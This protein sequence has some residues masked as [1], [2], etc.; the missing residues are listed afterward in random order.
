MTLARGFAADEGNCLRRAQTNM[1]R[2]GSRAD[3]KT[4][5]VMMKKADIGAPVIDRAAAAS[6]AEAFFAAN[7]TV[8][9]LDCLFVDMTGAIRGKRLP[10]EEAIK[11]LS[12]GVQIPQSLYLLD[13][14]GEMTDAL[15]RGFGDGDPDGTAFAVMS[16]LSPV[17]FADPPRAQVLMTLYE[18]SG[19]PCAIE[20]RNVL[21]SVVARFAE[22]DLT[23]TVAVELEFFLIDQK[24]TPGGMIQP[25]LCPRTGE[26]ERSIAVYGIDDL[27]RYSGFIKAVREACRMEH[28]PATAAS[29]EYAPGQFEINLKHTPDPLVAGDQAVFLKQCIKLAAE[30]EGMRATFMAKPYE[31]KAGSGMHVHMSL[32]DRGGIN[33]FNDGSA[34]GSP[35]LHHAAAGLAAIMHEGMAFFSQNSN[36][37]RRFVPN[38]FVPMNRRWGVNNRSTGIRVPAGLPEAKRLEHRV[39]AADAN[40]YLV[41]A[42]VLAGAHYGMTQKLD[43]GEPFVG[44]AAEFIDPTVPFTLEGALSALESSTILRGYLG[45]YIDSYVASKR[46]ERERFR[47]VITPHEYDWYL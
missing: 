15:G 6:E 14:R 8:T 36:A 25:P 27:D 35:L 44:N 10:R 42:V 32:V 16:T 28:V 12:N 19:E 17:A 37:Y 2:D 40:P 9:A 5:E 38:L 30:R 29:S 34:E 26:R 21:K 41:L 1:V 3:R 18:P 13:A 23:P 7:P 11:S 39:A 43:P 45:G 20:P 31:N 33:V 24:R 47:G 22:F 4:T 46:K